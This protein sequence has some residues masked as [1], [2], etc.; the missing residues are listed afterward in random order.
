MY[1]CILYACCSTSCPS[2]WWNQDAYLGPATLMQAYRR[3]AGCREEG[4]APEQDVP[5]QILYDFQLYVSFCLLLYL[6]LTPPLGSRTSQSEAIAKINL[7]MATR[8]Y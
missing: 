3:I 1:E 6:V 7:Q 5:V 4:K 2:Y 8:K